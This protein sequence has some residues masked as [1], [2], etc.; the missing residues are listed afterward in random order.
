MCI[1]SRAYCALECASVIPGTK[2]DGIIDID[3]LEKWIDEVRSLAKKH[4][5]AIIGDQ[6]VG[7]LLAG[8]GLGEDGI[9]PRE[10]V[11][12]VFEK[13]SSQEISRGME[14]NRYNSRG[15]SIR[16]PGA[17]EEIGLAKTYHEHADALMNEMP[18]TSRM[19]RNLA[20]SYERDA[21]WWN[22]DERVRRR[23]RA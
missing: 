16:G 2:E 3:S 11:R 8:C 5:R 13:I 20:S 19:L 4:G 18:F 1:A 21:E 22:S 15:A 23:L 14:I 17:T 10:E 12:Q 7:Q 9:W 6:Q